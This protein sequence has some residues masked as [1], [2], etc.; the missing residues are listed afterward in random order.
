MV[1]RNEAQQQQLMDVIKVKQDQLRMSLEQQCDLTSTVRELQDS[2][3]HNMVVQADQDREIQ[4]LKARLVEFQQQVC[5]QICCD[6]NNNVVH[7]K[8]GC[9]PHTHIHTC[10]HAP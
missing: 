6:Q 1:K 3:R 4:R 9:K 10:T 2:Q 8:L 5:M 7:H